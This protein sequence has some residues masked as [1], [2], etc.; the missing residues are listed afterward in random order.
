MLLAKYIQI[1]YGSM[2]HLLKIAYENPETFSNIT[3][4]LNL[5]RFS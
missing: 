4:S 1:T 5:D 3:D 2:K